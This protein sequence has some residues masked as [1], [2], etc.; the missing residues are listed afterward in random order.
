MQSPKLRINLS[1][2]RK[3]IHE[4]N[5]RGLKGRRESGAFLLG[6][7]GTILITQFICYDDLDP[8]AFSTGIITFDGDGFI[9]L[10]DYCLAHGLKV[11]A[12]VH[13]HPGEWTQQ[14]GSDKR[15][16]IIAQP[17][18]IALIVPHFATRRNQLL[19]GVG[20]HEFLGDRAW[21]SWDQEEHIVELISKIQ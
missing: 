7:K 8:D 15:Y 10:W 16:P 12:D 9:P 18:H 11:L 14:S 4:L 13:T 3:L 2:W 5:R 6:K 20:V 1:L 19:N 17:G 21:Q